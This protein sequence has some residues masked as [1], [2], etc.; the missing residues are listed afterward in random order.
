MEILLTT[1]SSMWPSHMIIR[2]T[3]ISNYSTQYE[4]SGSVIQVYTHGDFSKRGMDWA[5]P[6]EIVHTNFIVFDRCLFVNNHGG[7]LGGVL[8]LS[9]GMMTLRNCEFR[10]NSAIS[11][12]G[13][14]RT[15]GVA[16]LN[17]G[18]SLA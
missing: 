5:R 1:L 15:V 14:L 11:F 13:A 3:I 7:T 8:T 2:D 6:L 9:N 18:L 12:G 10:N 16:T 4:I 17:A